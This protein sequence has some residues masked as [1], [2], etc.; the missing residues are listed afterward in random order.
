MR[1][2]SVSARP[3]P[4]PRSAGTPLLGNRPGRLGVVT[5]IGTVTLGLLITIGSGSEPGLILGLSLVAG[6]AAAAL[7]VRPGALYLLF[8]VPAACY[9]VAA[10]IA[11]LVHDHA[12][13][14]SLTALAL[15]F[16]QWIAS[17]FIAMVVATGLAAVIAGCRWL[18][19]PRPPSGVASS[20]RER[21]GLRSPPR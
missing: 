5:L 21:R 11:G 2:R 16:A 6:T 19:A 7:A 14:S 8:P 4:Q 12:A 9:S 17:G 13:D 15:N 1:A 3:G 10:V 20:H 18:R